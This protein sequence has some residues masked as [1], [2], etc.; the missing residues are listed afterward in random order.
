MQPSLLECLHQ[1]VFLFCR[2]ENDASLSIHNVT[3]EDAGLYECSAQ[4]A[5]G[6][7]TVTARVTVEGKIYE[8]FMNYHN[9]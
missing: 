3:E 2:I 6:Y 4:N 7:A 5:A 1:K 8:Q 9:H